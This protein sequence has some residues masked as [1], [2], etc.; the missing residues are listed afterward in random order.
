[1]V[2]HAV[3]IG[4]MP[5][6]G[7]PKTETSVLVSYQEGTILSLDNCYMMN[8]V[9][10]SSIHESQR[11]ATCPLI[12]YRQPTYQSDNPVGLTTHCVA[13]SYEYSSL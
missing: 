6:M 10:G 5:D 8:D 4:K 3:D 12:L 13:N 1:M 11:Q 9:E 2:L 7:F